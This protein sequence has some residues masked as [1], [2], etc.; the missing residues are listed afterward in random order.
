MTTPSTRAAA[1]WRPR[2]TER[3]VRRSR[4]QLTKPPTLFWLCLETCKRPSTPRLCLNNLCL[5]PVLLCAVKT[6]TSPILMPLTRA[7]TRRSHPHL[8]VSQAPCASSCQLWSCH[9]PPTPLCRESASAR[10][11]RSLL[12]LQGGHWPSLLRWQLP[13][14]RPLNL[15]EQPQLPLCPLTSPLYLKVPGRPTTCPSSTTRRAPVTCRTTSI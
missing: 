4:L 14:Y 11:E 12:L 7:I 15:C 8:C 13:Q 1:S 3:V 10:A 9:Q 5:P 6:G 2:D